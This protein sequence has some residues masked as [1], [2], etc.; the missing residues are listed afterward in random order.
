MK[1]AILAIFL[2]L[3]LHSINTEQLIA[4]GSIDD[5]IQTK[6]AI[7]KRASPFIPSPLFVFGGIYNLLKK[8][9]N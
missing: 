7:Q 1:L 9:K 4:N 5:I 3:F 8:K 6:K 2:F